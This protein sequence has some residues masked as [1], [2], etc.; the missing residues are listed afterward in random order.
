MNKLITS[1]EYLFYIIKTNKSNEFSYIS[2][3]IE[4][5]DEYNLEI[6]EDKI[7]HIKRIELLINIY[8]FELEFYPLCLMD[9]NNNQIKLY[10]KDI[11]KGIKHISDVFYSEKELWNKPFLYFYS[12][13]LEFL[14][15]TEYFI[16]ILNTDDFN[17]QTMG[18]LGKNTN[19]TII[20]HFKNKNFNVFN[21]DEIYKYLSGVIDDILR[22]TKMN[23]DISLSYFL[24][25]YDTAQERNFSPFCLLET[26]DYE[27]FYEEE[28][29]KKHQEFAQD[30]YLKKIAEIKSY[31]IDG[32]YDI[33]NTNYFNTIQSLT[34][35]SITLRRNIINYFK[36]YLNSDLQNDIFDSLLCIITRNFFYDVG[37]MQ[38][39]LKLVL[40]NTF[41]SNFNSLLKKNIYRNFI[42]TKNINETN[43][44]IYLA[45]KSKLTLQ[46]L[47]LLGEDFCT[48]FHEKIFLPINPENKEEGSIFENVIISL[49]QTL[50]YIFQSHTIENELPQ[51]KL[52]VIMSNLIDFIIEFLVTKKKFFHILEKQIFELLFIEPK[53]IDLL[54][55]K[56]NQN[57]KTRT[58][59]ITF[60]KIKVINLITTYIQ[61]GK[62]FNTI[63]KLEEL[64]ITSLDLFNEILY[65]FHLLIINSFK[66]IPERINELNLKKKDESFVKELIELYIYEPLFRETLK[67]T[68]FS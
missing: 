45:N 11:L 17:L 57:I 33:N 6:I 7:K 28:K 36:S 12:L 67:L 53:I 5:E 32:F 51:D 44:H 41:F 64:D 3:E 61:N 46:F 16:H 1:Q 65:Y 63:Q 60:C 37:S 29:I 22:K 21:R 23:N 55:F 34:N 13:A 24:A 48:D 35:E 9:Y 14:P 39:N 40:D 31:Y 15:K 52:I 56:G 59:I 25:L 58:K 38:Q 43:R 42:L 47:Q 30:V 20:N 26:K 68:I 66:I 50:I 4:N 18:H 62:K 2:K 19:K 10:S 49:K 8:I 27:F 54:T